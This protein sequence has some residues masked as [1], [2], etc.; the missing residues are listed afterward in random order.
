MVASQHKGKVTPLE[1]FLDFPAQDF[2]DPGDLRQVFR[3]GIKDPLLL[4]RLNSEIP[5]IVDRVPEFRQA[6]AYSGDS[7]RGRAHVD[8]APAGTQIHRDS[9]DMDSHT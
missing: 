9:Y 5:F 8:A 6:G 2:Y 7:D 4:L 3:E 1:N